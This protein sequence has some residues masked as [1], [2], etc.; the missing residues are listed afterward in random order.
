VRSFRFDIGTRARKV[1]RLIGRV[2]SELLNALAEEMRASGVTS[3]DLARKLN[4]PSSV[5]NRQLAGGTIS[6]RSLADLA[7]ALDRE[8]SFKLTR[9]IERAGQ[10]DHSETSTIEAPQVRIVGVSA[11]SGSTPPSAPETRVTNDRANRDA[12]LRIFHIL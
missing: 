11:P 4:I 1:A 10:N 6:L 12:T 3:K 8:I 2:Q 7:W 9:P 5:I